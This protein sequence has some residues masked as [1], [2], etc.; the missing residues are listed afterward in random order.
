MIQWTLAIQPLVPLLFLNPAENI[1]KFSVHVLLKPSLK[2]FENCLASMWD[3][4][5][6]LV[7]GTFF[8]IGIKSDLFQ[9]CGHYWLF[10]ICWHIEDIALTISA[11]RIWNIS[12]GIPSPPL[13]WFVLMLP[14]VHLTSHSRMSGSRW[15]TT[16]LW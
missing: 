4:C 13:V 8:G 5:N 2:D 7:A 6:C 15:V 1:W 9:S 3:E 10:Q 12:A 11:F 16:S 14:K